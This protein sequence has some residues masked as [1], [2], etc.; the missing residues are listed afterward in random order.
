M[1][2]LAGDSVFD[3]ASYDRPS[4]IEQMGPGCRLIAR[5][6]A[7][8]RSVW[9]QVHD[10]SPYA[11]SSLVLSVGGN[12]ALQ[13]MELVTS[14]RPA[15]EVLSELSLRATAFELDYLRLLERLRSQ[16]WVRLVVCTIYNGNFA[17]G[18]AAISGGVRLFNDAIQSAARAV[19]A[20]VIDLRELFT[21]GADFANQIEPS[22]RGSA[23]LAAAIR[24]AVGEERRAA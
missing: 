24:A 20:P 17:S 8:V 16:G 3:N 14:K 22:A 13:S 1:I 18:R 6:G 21:D 12:D 23:K 2:F 7:V 9:R 10:L 11:T 15:V 4:L 5:D 19:Q